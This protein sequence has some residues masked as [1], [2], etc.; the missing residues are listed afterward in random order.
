MV[1]EHYFLDG[2]EVE[3]GVGGLTI[4]DEEAKL[5]VIQ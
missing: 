3:V 4:E 5:V 2:T 1:F